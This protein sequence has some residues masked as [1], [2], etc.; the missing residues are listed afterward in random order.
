MR[1]LPKNGT[2]LFFLISA[3]LFCGLRFVKLEADFP[4]GIEHGGVLYTDEGWYSNAAINRV[5]DG[6]WYKEGDFN[7][8]IN[9]PVAHILQRI[10]FALFGMSLVSARI[11]VILF[12]MLFLFTVFQLVRT[13]SDSQTG[14]AS[15][16]T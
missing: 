1:Q 4:L 16:A 3:I 7:P 11:T 12:F 14:R 15:P 5:V 8:A 6:K 13:F 10:T 2:T 9:L